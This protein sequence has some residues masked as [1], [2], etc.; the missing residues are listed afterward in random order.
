MTFLRSRLPALGVL[1]VATG[2]VW[3]SGWIASALPQSEPLRAPVHS[4]RTIDYATDVVAP[5]SPFTNSRPTW[6]Q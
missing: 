3:G 4:V 1:A 6:D 2:L 5:G